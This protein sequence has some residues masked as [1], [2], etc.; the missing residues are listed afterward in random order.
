[1]LIPHRSNVETHRPSSLQ[2]FPVLLE[3]IRTQSPGRVLD[4]V[5]GLA[6]EPQPKSLYFSKDRHLTVRGHAVAADLIAR[7]LAPAS[8]VASLR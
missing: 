4:L 5:N 6:R 3:W 8:A 1:M 7:F 2:R